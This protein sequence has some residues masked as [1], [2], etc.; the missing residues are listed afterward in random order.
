MS[1]I[2]NIQADLDAVYAAVAEFGTETVTIGTREV[3]CVAGSLAQ[4]IDPSFMG[5][6]R[7]FAVK[8]LVKASNFSTQNP[9]PAE[10]DRVV[11]RNRPYLIGTIENGIARLEYEFTLVGVMR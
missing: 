9:L 10:G 6:P 3:P 2:S 7:E 5:D 4:S 11:Y 1:T 8:I